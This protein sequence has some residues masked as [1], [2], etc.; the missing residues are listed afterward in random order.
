[1]SNYF[2]DLGLD[3]KLAIQLKKLHQANGTTVAHLSKVTKVSNQTIF[4]WQAGSKPR[5]LDQ[6][7]KI[8]DHFKVSL[9][10]L[11]YGIEPEVRQNSPLNDFDSEINAGIYE[12]VLRRIKKPGAKE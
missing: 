5:D 12:V 4:N 7:K 10:Y 2:T 6:V 11:V 3:M 8:A 1:M 9:D